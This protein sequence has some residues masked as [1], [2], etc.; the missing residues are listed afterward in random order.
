MK[1]KQNEA[2]ECLR[3]KDA[4]GKGCNGKKKGSTRCNICGLLV[5]FV[6]FWKHPHTSIISYSLIRMVIFGL[7]A[8]CQFTPQSL[9]L[10]NVAHLRNAE[11]KGIV[12]LL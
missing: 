7:L 2:L 12:S 4:K 9:S 8:L 11:G 5:L 10:T 6:C 3:I 1:V